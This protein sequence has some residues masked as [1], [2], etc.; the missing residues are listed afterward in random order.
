MKSYI[1]VVNE[2]KNLSKSRITNIRKGMLAGHMCRPLSPYLSAMFIKKGISPNTVTLM[3]IGWGVLGSALFA[4]PCL[5]CKIAGYICFYL[6]FTMD[7]CDGEVARTTKQFSKYGKEMDYMAHLICHPLM[8][9][10]MWITYLQAD[11]YDATMLACIFITI[12]SVELVMR[13]LI[14]FDSYLGNVDENSAKQSLPNYFR[15]LINQ[16]ILYPNFIL[17]FTLFVIW[18]YFNDFVCQTIYLLLLWTVC[19]LLVVLKEY[20][21]RLTFYYKN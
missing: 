6:W 12:I 16:S 4:I 1:N 7:L 11:K 2:I 13:N 10:A 14:S 21:K 9:I 5:W 15:Y 18:D 20:Y 8:N 17:V 3:M 19:F